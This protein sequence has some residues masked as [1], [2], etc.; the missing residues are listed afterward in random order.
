MTSFINFDELVS[1][2]NKRH[3]RI[4]NSLKDTLRKDGRV[5]AKSGF[6]KNKLI[7]LMENEKISFKNLDDGECEISVDNFIPTFEQYKMITKSQVMNEFNEKRQQIE[8]AVEIAKK[9]LITDLMKGKNT[10]YITPELSLFPDDGDYRVRGLFKLYVEK[11][12]TEYLSSKNYS[13][14]MIFFQ[15]YNQINIHYD[16]ISNI[17]DELMVKG[18]TGINN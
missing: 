11:R 18:N 6:D 12:L 7:E 3:D 10:I 16:P 4:L 15:K 17:I 14:S 13:F 1:K 8:R 9:N 5:V 2:A